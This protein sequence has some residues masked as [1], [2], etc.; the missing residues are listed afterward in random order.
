MRSGGR[1]GPARAKAEEHANAQ[2]RRLESAEAI[3]A[4]NVARIPEPK[5]SLD[6]R[7]SFKP[8]PAHI[9]ERKRDM[10]RHSETVEL[11]NVATTPAL[12][13]G[14]HRRCVFCRGEVC[15]ADRHV[16]ESLPR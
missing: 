6:R 3:E 9:D 10:Q 15:G 14:V 12:K 16:P 8:A 7:G 5:C 11:C 13:E 2:R 1:E 4:R